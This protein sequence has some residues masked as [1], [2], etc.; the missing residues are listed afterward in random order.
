MAQMT[1]EALILANDCI[2]KSLIGFMVETGVMT[3]RQMLE[4]LEAAA[5]SQE[6]AKAQQDNQMAADHIRAIIAAMNS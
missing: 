1:S 4:V 3:Q 2:L 6:G 5:A